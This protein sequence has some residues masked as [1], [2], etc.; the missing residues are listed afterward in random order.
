MEQ[1]EE[2][3]LNSVRCRADGDNS[4]PQASMKCQG[5]VHA[6]YSLSGGSPTVYSVRVM[7]VTGESAGIPLSTVQLETKSESA[8]HLSATSR[9]LHMQRKQKQNTVEKIGIRVAIAS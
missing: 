9:I 2:G 1:T 8:K 5:T 6:V 4:Y 3:V 7:I